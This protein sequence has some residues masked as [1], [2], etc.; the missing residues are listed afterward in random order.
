LAWSPQTNTWEI[1]P[2]D[3]A[4]ED[5]TLA[6]PLPLEALT[7]TAKTDDAVA[8]ALLAK[9]NPV[10]EGALQE[11]ERRGVSKGKVVALLAVLS[12]RG[13]RVSKKAEQWIW[14]NEDE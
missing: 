5:P 3:G 10:I 1:L 9:K 14:A 8:R 13:V 4:I 12:A 2:K 11:A 6:L 7:G